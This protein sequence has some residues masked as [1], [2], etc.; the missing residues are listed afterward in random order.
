MYHLHPSE[1]LRRVF[2]ARPFQ[3]AEP[4]RASFLF[5]GLDANYSPDIERSAIFP[6]LLEYLSDG[7]AFWQKTGVQHPFLLPA[8]GNKDGTKYHRTFATIGFRPEQAPLV[9]FIEILHLPTYGRSALDVRDLDASHLQ[10]LDWV[11]RA[12]SARHVFVPSGVARLM[13]ASGAFRWLPKEA[14]SEGRALTVWYRSAATT[15]YCHYHLST[16]G[17]QEQR[18]REQIAEIRSLVHAM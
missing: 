15:F 13:R 18:K 12:G 8:Y 17:H 14:D 3:G 11:M 7:V 4:E 2:A 1:T 9:S 5:V 10:R 6:Q 16:Y